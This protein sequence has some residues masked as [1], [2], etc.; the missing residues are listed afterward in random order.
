M[1]ALLKNLAPSLTV[2]AIV[3]WC[4]WSQPT[5]RSLGPNLSTAK[6]AA[7]SRLSRTVLAPE[8]A[9]TWSR[10]PFQVLAT[11]GP[12]STADVPPE[13]S[14]RQ[15][16]E[17]AARAERVDRPVREPE[18]SIPSFHLGATYLRG[19]QRMALINGRVYEPGDVIA[20]ESA[21]S[22]QWALHD[23]RRHDV[24]LQAENRFVV[25]TYRGLEDAP[26]SIGGALWNRWLSPWLTRPE[27]REASPTQA[28]EG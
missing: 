27:R 12:E 21:P 11:N 2:F 25:L 16:S 1:Q 10:D 9:A 26:A 5:S 22:T 3:A 17:T 28:N 13:P 7:A 8:I 20:S 4:V 24:V 14:V 23:I 15:K 6:P 18:S 19:A